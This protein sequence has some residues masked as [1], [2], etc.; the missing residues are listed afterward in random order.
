MAR[1]CV[2]SRA[3]GKKVIGPERFTRLARLF[4]CT[5]LLCICALAP[6]AQG[7]GSDAQPLKNVLGVWG[8][9]SFDS[10]HVIGVTSN[11][12]LGIL[13][14]RYGRIL[15]SWDNLSLEYT[16]D[17]FPLVL[18]DQPTVMTT[19]LPGPPP[20]TIYTNTGREA[21]Y[22]GGVNPIG[23]KLNFLHQRRFEPF[24]RLEPRIRHFGQARSVRR[25]RRRPV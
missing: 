19:F 12:R 11:R 4:L 13:A 23:L 18:I 21:V 16:V 6:L 8:G 1:N 9:Y 2:E 10:P 17:V 5:A 22:G 3:W 25:S 14:F 24:V 20:V 15:H 7:Q